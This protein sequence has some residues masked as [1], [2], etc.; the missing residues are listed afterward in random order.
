MTLISGALLQ[1]K[2]MEQSE[3]EARLAD[4][5]LG[6]EL[7]RDG[8]FV[9]FFEASGLG[10]GDRFVW[11]FDGEVSEIV[12]VFEA[13]QDGPFADK[14]DSLVHFTTPDYEKAAVTGARQLGKYLAN[15]EIAEVEG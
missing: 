10:V 14:G 5:P 2:M 3:R 7:P 6:P 1:Q 15:E 4:E 8:D 9:A 11:E 12:A 13:R